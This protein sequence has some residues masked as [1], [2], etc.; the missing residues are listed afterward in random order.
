MQPMSEKRAVNFIVNSFVQSSRSIE[1]ATTQ[2]SPPPSPHAILPSSRCGY[3]ARRCGEAGSALLAGDGRKP[4]PR[5]LA[6]NGLPPAT[7]GKRRGV[8]PGPPLHASNGASG[9]PVRHTRGPGVMD[10]SASS[11][12]AAFSRE[13]RQNPFR[14][15]RAQ[16]EPARCAKPDKTRPGNRRRTFL[17]PAF[18]ERPKSRAKTAER[19]AERRHI[20]S[21]DTAASSA[22]SEA[23]CPHP[24]VFFARGKANACPHA[25]R[26]R[27]ATRARPAGTLLPAPRT[28]AQPGRGHKSP[29][30]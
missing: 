6:E 14:P 7:R 20:H 8:G 28:V 15:G 4:S 30:G 10:A 18:A 26:N 17:R 16:G 9:V 13:R 25:P 3:T 23:R 12:G 27:R 19:G 5:G 2:F 1:L 22:P 11:A 21:S 29:S 24:G